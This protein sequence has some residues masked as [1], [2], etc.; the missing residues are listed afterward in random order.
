MNRPARPSPRPIGHLLA[1]LH[2]AVVLAGPLGASAAADHPVSAVLVADVDQVAPGVS[3]TIGVLLRMQPDWHTYWASGGDA[4]LPTQIEWNAPPGFEIGPLQWPGPRKFA[5]GGLTAYGYADEVLLAASVAPP[6]TLS[7][8]REIE[9]GAQVSWLACRDICIPGNAETHLRLP[10]RR[11]SS[12]SAASDL[13]DRYGGEVPSPLGPADPL[14]LNARVSDVDGGLL[15]DLELGG[16]VVFDEQSP[17][18]FPLA[19]ETLYAR[20]I[21][22]VLAGSG[23][24]LARLQFDIRPYDDRPPGHLEGV[25]VYRRATGG[26]LQYRA[27]ELDLSV[28]SVP[29]GLLASS[30]MAT[31]TAAPRSLYAYLL[32]ALVGGLILNLMPCVLPIISIKVLSFVSQSGETPRRVRQLGLTFAA[33]VI[34]A[35]LAMAAIVVILKAGGEEIGWGFQFQAPGFIIFLAALVFVLGLSLFGLVTVRLPGTQGSMGGLA[36]REG[37]PGSFFNG[38]LATILATPCTAPF[39][40]VALGFAFSQSVGIIVA[41]FLSTGV[42]MATPYIA[43]ALRPGWTR[44]LP[45]PGLWMEH[46]KQLMGF[47]LMATVLWLL[48]VL[49]KQLGVEAVI[50]TAAFLLVLALVAWILGQW[51]DLGSSLGRRRLAWVLSLALAAGGYRLLI[52]PLLQADV[53]LRRGSASDASDLSAEWQPF[54]TALVEGLMRQHR[55][56][57]VDFTAE[58]CWT[59]KVNKRTTLD[60]DEVRARFAELDVALVRADWTNRNPEITELLRAFG[61][62]GVPLYVIFPPGRPQEP[63]VLPEILTS[64][65]VLEALARAA[66]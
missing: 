65:I 13:F 31:S 16:E 7:V 61:R 28:P 18:F 34:A 60:T 42:G 48:W 50:W 53:G 52:H 47:P 41:I 11:G 15:L 20:G 45:R 51:V 9:L 26:Q 19:I 6:D 46:F 33:G 12:P 3:F 23:E 63:V 44:L 38:V 27:V 35:F 30:H 14:T 57:F 55:M 21:S 49:G 37:L 24:V 64:G 17:D 54:S 29:A 39:L 25:V 36:D 32:M 62:S 22:R 8:G 4:G 10:V 1:A 66:E 43:L 40:G 2:A 59:C 58:W 56:V 5:E